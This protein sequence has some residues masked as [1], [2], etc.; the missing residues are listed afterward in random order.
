MDNQTLQYVEIANR[1]KRGTTDGKVLWEKTGNQ[2]QQYTARLDNGHHAL[3][4]VNPGSSVVV[5]TM[6]NAQ[7]VEQ[8]HLDTSR[9]A[10]DILR[11]ALLQ[12]FVAVRDTF[13]QRLAQDALDSLKNL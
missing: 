5:F 1:I 13:T 6:S 4:G 10:H 7:G 9:I 8:L 2:G 3:V 12:L 11:L